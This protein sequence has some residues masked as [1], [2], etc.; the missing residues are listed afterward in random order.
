MPKPPAIPNKKRAGIT[1]VGMS[2]PLTM[3]AKPG[4]KLRILAAGDLAE[5]E[6]K[7]FVLQSGNE[8]QECFVVRWHGELQSYVNRC[9][10]VSMT[11]DWVENQFLTNDGE[12]ILC[13]SHGALF[14]P[15]TGECIGGP[16]Y[17]KSLFRV[18]LVE[19]DGEVFAEWPEVE[20]EEQ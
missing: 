18:P 11:L 9:R 15:D 12:L 17:G 3:A 7:K 1:D 8:R 5:G 6:S 20:E 4:E 13:P 2:S 19:H 16:A 14:Q 10:H